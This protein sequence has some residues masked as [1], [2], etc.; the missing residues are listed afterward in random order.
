MT[1]PRGDSVRIPLFK[2]SSL[3]DSLWAIP[4]P[5][6]PHLFT[7]CLI[8]ANFATM[9]H[10]FSQRFRYVRK[11]EGRGGK[12]GKMKLKEYGMR[13]IGGVE[14]PCEEIFVARLLCYMYRGPP[15]SPELEAC[16]MCEKSLCMAPWHLVWDTHQSN[17]KG[18]YVHKKNKKN[19]HP[20]GNAQPA[21]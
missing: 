2:D 4:H 19:Y 14:I 5:T 9:L 13:L 21:V 20:Y 16:H 15:A 6:Q 10:G 8:P 17:I 7:K 18:Y 1:T 11:G 12:A 3:G